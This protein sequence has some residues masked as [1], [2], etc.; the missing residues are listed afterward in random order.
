MI[1]NQY[2][3]EFTNN[4]ELSNAWRSGHDLVPEYYNTSGFKYFK[5]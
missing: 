4:S 3:D 2:S 1:N 5:N